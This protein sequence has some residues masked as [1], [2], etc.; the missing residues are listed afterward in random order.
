PD[1]VVLKHDARMATVLARALAASIRRPTE[2][3]VVADGSWR[4]RVA[5]EALR[6]IV[7][8]VRREAPPHAAGRER[9]LARTV[10]LLQRQAEARR[11]E[12]PPES[13]LRR[14]SRDPAV[15]AF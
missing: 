14:M 15:R 4:W 13:W 1:V 10:A 6:R 5:V 12:S 3:L 2:E 7:D 11:G 9:V 8:D